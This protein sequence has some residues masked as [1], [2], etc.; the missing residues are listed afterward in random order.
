[1]PLEFSI[2]P[3]RRIILVRGHG[4]VTAEEVFAYQRDAWSDP[5]L[6]DYDEL[7]DMT[8][9]ERVVTPPE[10]VMEL[11]DLSAQMDPSASSPRT[12]IAAPAPS[13]FGLARR[14][15]AYRETNPHSTRQVTVFRTLAEALEWLGRE[16]SDKG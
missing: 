5:N 11:A 10:R 12:A 13:A 15:S 6:A 9:V 14:Y 1:M 4:T 3:T 2:D 7:I 8:G 16:D